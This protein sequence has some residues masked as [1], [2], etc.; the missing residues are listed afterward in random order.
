MAEI[1][2]L[3]GYRYNSE[4]FK[5]LSKVVTPPYDVID[6][7]AQENFYQTSPYNYIRLE[8]G[9]IFPEDNREN[10]VYT[11]AAETFHEWCS[12]N[13]LVQEPNPALYL[14]QQEYQVNGETK[15]RTGFMCGLKTEDYSLGNVLPHEETLPK[16]KA[17]RLELMRAT[18]ANFSPIFGLY[19]D[20]EKTIDKALLGSIKGKKPDSEMTD[21]SHEK[22][23]LWVITDNAVIRTVVNDMSQR[24]VYIADGHHRYETAVAYA[25]EMALKGGNNFDHVLITLVNLFDEGLIVLPTH[26]LVKN[27][28]DFS[29]PQFLKRIKVYFDV[30]NILISGSKEKA[31]NHLLKEL[32]QAGES[33]HA[34]G[35][36]G[37]DG[38]LY[39][40]TLKN[41]ELINQMT[42]LT[43]SRAWRQLDVTILH[44]LILENLLGIG[45]KERASEGF[46]QYTRQ[47][48]SAIEAVDR[49]ACQ[50]SLLMNPPQV[51]EITDVAGAGEKMPQKSTFF[52]PKIISGLIVN[53]LG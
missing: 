5:D 2:P 12:K 28:S 51:Q 38:N 15:I 23:R 52:Y 19:S 32:A 6:K 36:Y 44:S 25:Q 33:R 50:I 49:G 22:H 9:K 8:L 21:W 29:F 27:L 42:D 10:N 26:R 45:A 13:I 7:E 41:D 48:L 11:R 53:K 35:L 4:I 20:P 30:E 24:K 3:K 34:F 43:K 46:L 17:D 37:G 16:H 18:E 47:D 39:L 31:L 40:L 14:Y 1:K